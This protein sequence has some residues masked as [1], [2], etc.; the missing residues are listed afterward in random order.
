MWKRWLVIIGFAALVIA[1]PSAAKAATM[2][3]SPSSKTVTVGGSFT[4]II[5]VNT[6]GVAINSAQA[7][8]SYPSTLLE[9]TGISSSGIFTLWAI[10]PSYSN[11]AGTATF[12]G[13][14]PSPGY[15][16]SAGTAIGIVFRA[17][18]SG[19]AK[20]TISGASILANDG[21]GTDVFTGA[22]SGT[23]TI[24]AASTDT[25][26]TPTTPTEKKTPAAPTIS[27]TTHKDQTTWYSNNNPSFS[28][29]RES[30]VTGFSTSLDDQ[31]TKTPDTD[32]DTNDNS[33]SFSGTP[34]GTWYFHVRAKNNDGWGPAAHFK[35][36]IDTTAPETF[37]IELLDGEKTTTLSPR[38]SFTTTDALSGLKEYTLSVNGG[39][40]TT[41]ATDATQPYT[42][43]GLGVGEYT[44]AV[45]ANDNAGNSATSM[46]TF[47]IVSEEVTPEPSQPEPSLPGIAK[48]INNVL[49]SVNNILPAP[50]KNATQKISDTVK[51]WQAN[52][53]VVDTF[54]N[55][56]KP[57]ITA[58][59]IVTAVGVTTTSTALQLTNLLY[60]LLRFGY[61]WMAPIHFGKRRR[62][63]GIVFDSTTG[64]P[65]SRALVRIFAKEFNKLRESQITDDEGRFGFLI[66][67]GE[68][69]VT[70]GKP[71]YAFPSRFLRTAIVSQYEEIYRGGLFAVKDKDA[72][73]LTINIPIDPLLA[74]IS[75][76]R[77]KWLRILNVLGVVLEKINTPFL[78]AGSLLSVLT[79]MIEPQVSNFIILGV[80]FL[81]IIIKTVLKFV[82]G[83]SWGLVVDD[84][85][86]KPIDLAVVRIYDVST[87]NVMGTRV[88]NQLGQFTSFIT[89]GEY[90][91]VILKEGYESFRSKPITVTRRRGLIRMKA[92]L[93]PKEKSGA[94]P[95][96]EPI[97]S[98]ESADR[99]TRS[100]PRLTTTSAASATLTDQ[101]PTPPEPST[102]GVNR[103]V[104]K[105]P[106]LISPQKKKRTAK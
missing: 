45:T 37:T 16:G 42:L 77:M 59:A 80:Y 90:Y 3:V 4:V 1:I 60:L 83:R 106:P 6:G 68:Y 97:I 24:N 58:T 86:G 33:Q 71:G 47:R 40:V 102:K 104:F 31:P 17:K 76:I 7:T 53:G 21:L 44:V 105:P 85:T 67:P 79:V 81:L 88:T 93:V 84:D 69:F 25:P 30:G 87:G 9:A 74:T 20:V 51:D 64:R 70:V 11:A 19:S 43:A 78:I 22:G 10:Q 92:G 62:P 46:V 75:A 29:T 100:K 23:Y 89:P 15:T 13:G 27:S 56:V 103:S 39:P 26:Q 57:T 34:N 35:I 12:A 36:N 95:E 61:F 99:P 2:Y 50:I 63:W 18:A 66:S 49:K 52:E 94:I 73:T 32:Q 72:N 82:I 54:D 55:V 91:V 28:W 38:L 48:T 8:I 5:G 65:V 96:G 101:S 98:L 14:L 41:V